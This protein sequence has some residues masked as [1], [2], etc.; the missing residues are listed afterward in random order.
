MRLV[1]VVLCSYTSHF[2]RHDDHESGKK[3]VLLGRLEKYHKDMV[4]LAHTTMRLNNTKPISVNP[5]VCELKPRSWKRS[6]LVVELSWNSLGRS[7]PGPCNAGCWCAYG[8]ICATLYDADASTKAMQV[9]W[10]FSVTRNCLSFK[11]QMKQYMSIY[12]IL[13]TQKPTWSRWKL[14]HLGKSPLPFPTR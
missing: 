3:V 7:C 2:Q 13:L 10:G 6:S 11:T 5:S 14:G 4:Q 8:S 1:M 9:G 12:V